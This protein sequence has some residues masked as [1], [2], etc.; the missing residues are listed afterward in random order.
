MEKNVRVEEND[1]R[2]FSNKY[3]SSLYIKAIV[4]IHTKNKTFKRFKN[5]SAISN[6]KT[7]TDYANSFLKSLA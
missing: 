3:K 2:V 7:I 6:G 1:C 4:K 5:R